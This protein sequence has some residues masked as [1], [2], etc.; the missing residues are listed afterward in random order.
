MHFPFLFLKNAENGIILQS[1]SSGYSARIGYYVPL[2]IMESHGSF[3]SY[4][5]FQGEEN[6]Q[7]VAETFKTPTN[8]TDYCNLVS[9]S[10]CT[11]D[12]GIAKRYP[13]T[14]E[15]GSSYFVEDAY[16]GHFRTTFQNNCTENVNCTGSAVMYKCDAS[17]YA[18][19]QFYWND[20]RLTPDGTLRAGGYEHSHMLQIY[21]A[22]N[23]TKSGVFMLF[24]EPDRFIEKFATS[25]SMKMK[26]YVYERTNVLIFVHPNRCH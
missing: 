15:E 23:A 26:R 8:W 11:I 22:A 18:D 24:Y 12:D 5:G 21:E 10:N 19:N 6:K 20:I 25:R 3:A 4:Y 13:E 2:H 17:V 7:K 14:T 16:I 1:E 9:E